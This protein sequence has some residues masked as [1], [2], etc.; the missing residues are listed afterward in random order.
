[1]AKSNGNYTY[2]GMAIPSGEAKYSVIRWGWNGLNRTDKIDTGQLTDCSGITIDPPYVYPSLKPHKLTTYAEPISIHGF[3]DNL[4][5]IYRDSGEIKIDCIK[6]NLAVYTGVMGSAKGND[7]DFAPRSMVQFNVASNV[8]NIVEAEYVRKILIFPDSYSIDFNITSDFTP[9]YLGDAYPDLMLASVYGSRVFGVDE[10]LVYASSYNDYADWDLDTA[11]EY[12]EANAWVSM[13]QSNVKADGV[14][15]AISTYDNHVVLFKKDFMQLVYNNKNPFRV[16]DVG[17]WGCDNAYSVAEC[18]GI[19]Y[20][21]SPDAVYSFGG[22]TPREISQKLGIKSFAGASLGSYDGRLFMCCG[23][24]IYTYKDGIWSDS[25]ECASDVVC[26]ATVSYGIAALC[27]NGDIIFLDWDKDDETSPSQGWDEEYGS[28]DGGGWWF[29][30]D[31]MAAGKLDVRRV[32]KLSLLCELASGAE[33]MVYI[34]K[35]GEKF[36]SDTSLLAGSVSGEGQVM[37]RAMI[38]SCSAYMHRLRIAG[39]G[40]AKIYAAELQISWGGDLY[41]EG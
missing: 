30:T 8:E 22:G 9:A 12:S 19:L 39:R 10:N 17:S 23:G 15:T 36:N 26:F 18:G 28:S 25:G 34:L 5:V 21:A 24:K 6:K 13:S 11:D 29:E 3:G 35:D 38:R 33:V 7:A 40:Y 27:K 20:F 2:G 4:F 32:K 31:L 1:M 37:L 16:V 14:F 41:K